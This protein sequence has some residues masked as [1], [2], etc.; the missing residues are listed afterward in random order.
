[1]VF[2]LVAD[3]FFAG[4]S[5]A[6]RGYRKPA[7]IHTRAGVGRV[8]WR[9]FSGDTGRGRAVGCKGPAKPGSGALEPARRVVLGAILH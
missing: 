7:I 9:V 8:F 2:F 3:F 1:L 4:I 6:P 5:S